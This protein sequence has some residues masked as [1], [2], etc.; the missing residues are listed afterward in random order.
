MPKG[1]D[2]ILA[3]QALF[4]LT[5]RFEMAGDPEENE[6]SGAVN[7]RIDNAWPIIA[8]RV[9]IIPSTARCSWRLSSISSGPRT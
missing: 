3:A 7:D 9:R 4:P 8:K 5:A 1:L 2:N 6:V